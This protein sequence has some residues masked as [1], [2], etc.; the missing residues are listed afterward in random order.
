MELRRAARVA[1]L[2]CFI[3]RQRRLGAGISD[4]DNSERAQDKGIN[5]L[6]KLLRDINSPQI[7]FFVARQD[8]DMFSSKKCLIFQ[9][10]L[11]LL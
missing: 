7:H 4:N 8:V 10:G 1:P 6:L 11:G 3:A 9:M 5:H 2:P